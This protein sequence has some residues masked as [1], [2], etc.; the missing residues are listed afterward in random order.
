MPMTLPSSR[1]RALQLGAL[2]LAMSALA[3]PA[4]ADP[5][6]ALDRASLSLGAFDASPR[7]GL[8]ADTSFGHVDTGD[9]DL[10]RVT[11]PRI[12]AEMLLGDTQGLSLDY[13]RYDKSYSTALTGATTSAGAPL[14]GDATLDAQLKLDLAEF[15]YKWWLGRG[16]DVFGLGVGA[17]YYHVALDGTATGTVAGL[18][19]TA[20]GSDSDD[21]FAPLLELGWR[22]AFNS[23][24]RMYAE[25]SGIRKNGGRLNGHIYGG[26]LGVEWFPARDV[27]LVADYGVSNIQ[28][29]RDSSGSSD[30]IDLHLRGPSLFLK[31]RF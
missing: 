19:S 11:L 23:S 22:H 21:A 1:R 2:C 13:Y 24:W 29:N 4:S 25:A 18:S 7:I 27:G 14:T 26:A 12:R 28:I 20:S 5:S 3:A 31:V 9:S 30:D 6:P 10:D 16:S 17:G 15:A 8:N